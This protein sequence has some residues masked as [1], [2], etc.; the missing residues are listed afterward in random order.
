[1]TPRPGCV[2]VPACGYAAGT[3]A[4]GSQ[5]SA[6]F[7]ARDVSGEHRVGVWGG[8]RRHASVSASG[9]GSGVTSLPLQVHV[10]EHARA[11][12]HTC[13]CRGMCMCASTPGGRCQVLARACHTHARV[14]EH[15]H[16]GACLRAPPAPRPPPPSGPPPP[17]AA[18][19]ACDVCERA[20]ARVYVLCTCACTWRGGGGMRAYVCVCARAHVCGGGGGARAWRGLGGGRGWGDACVRGL[21]V[22][23]TFTLEEQHEA[24]TLENF[25]SAC[26]R[27]L[28]RQGENRRQ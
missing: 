21:R 11:C 1:M 18:S 24:P 8:E 10:C 13:T 5:A 23:G 15:A 22:C 9:G 16:A 28:R 20:R 6:A 17:S 2:R 12:S 25:W 7:A 3:V 19:A 14:C 4:D 27:G 26:T